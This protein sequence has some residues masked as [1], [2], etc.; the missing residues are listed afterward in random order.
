[1]KRSVTKLDLQRTGKRGGVQRFHLGTITS[2]QERKDD[3]TAV[4]EFLGEDNEVIATL[5][6]VAAMPEIGRLTLLKDGA[7]IRAGFVDV[8]AF[9][10]MLEAGL[11]GERTDTVKAVAPH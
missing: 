1:M 3:D 5:T 2:I 6:I 4:F 9:Q 8:V 10:Q 11:R 7:A